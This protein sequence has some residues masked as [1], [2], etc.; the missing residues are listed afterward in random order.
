MRTNIFVLLGFFIMA[1]GLLIYSV[2][3]KTFFIFPGQK[4]APATWYEVLIAISGF[5]IFI[6]FILFG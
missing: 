6:S 4:R 5:A 1:I 2:R 3:T